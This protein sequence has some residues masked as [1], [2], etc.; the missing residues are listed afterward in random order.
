[1]EGDTANSLAR[2]VLQ[3]HITAEEDSDIAEP[4]KGDPCTRNEKHLQDISTAFRSAASVL[5]TGQLV[6]DPYFTLFEAVGALEIMDPKMDSGFLREGETLEDEFDVLKELLPEEVV[7][8]MDQILCHEMAWH[9]GHPLSQSLFTSYHIDRLLWPEPKKLEEASFDR[10]APVTGNGMLHV[11][12]RAYCLALIKCCDHVHRRVGAEHYYEEEDFVSNLYNRNLLSNFDGAQVEMLLYEAIRFTEQQSKLDEALRRAILARLTLRQRI[13]KAMELDLNL[14]KANRIQLWKDCVDLLPEL[15]QTQTLGTPVKEAF[16]VKMQRKLAS[17][18]PPRPMV[19]ITFEDAHAFLNNLCRDAADVYLV[20]D[21]HGCSNL[22]N[23]TYVFQSRKPQPAIY[24]RCLLQSLIFHD[25]RVLGK[26]TITTL[27]YDD[28][29]ELVLPADV[30]LDPANGNVEAPHDPRFQLAEKMSGFVLRIGDP[31]LDIFRAICMNR[32][33]ARR[34]LCHLVMEWESVQLEAENLDVELRKYTGEKP[35]TDGGPT[36]TEIW[37]FPLSSWA[38]YYKLRQMEWIVQLGFELA[39]YQNDELSAMHLSH[40]AGAKIQHVERIQTF[41]TRRFRQSK[42]WSAKHRHSFKQ[43]FSF[44]EV[45]LTEASATQ[46]F[47][48]SLSKLYTALSHFTLLPSRPQPLPYSTSELR[49][50]LRMRPFM[51]LSIP[52]VPSYS[53]L[54]AATSTMSEMERSEGAS[55]A[56]GQALSILDIA[57]EASKVARKEWE[58]LSKLDAQAARCVDCEEWWRKSIK[59]VMRA[60]ILCSIAIAATKKG[61]MNAQGKAVRKS[62]EAEMPADGK[63]YH[64][65]WVVPKLTIQS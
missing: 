42:R 15:S 12:F 60:C 28:L 9:M 18:V 14:V 35:L 63:S 37:S 54:T 39:I 6:K 20:L 40:V 49:H 57:D 11:V 46:W 23:F 4:D 26:I 56:E 59:D 27:I 50:A 22:L 43:C 25:M 1:M 61:V 17:S 7:G 29:A 5:D 53:E 62:L 10:Q 33:R 2:D 19:E 45:T 24:I 51:Q 65:F 30:L 38:Y 34:M 16:S 32:S 21:Y 58:A 36:G 31:F 13:L 8:L 55:S 52:E 44:L 3:L 47:A 64:D 48:I 41:V